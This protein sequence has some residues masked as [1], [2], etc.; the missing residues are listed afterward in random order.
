MQRPLSR[1][2]PWRYFAL[3]V[4]VLGMG[5]LAHADEL[6]EV[7][8]LYYSGQATLAMDRADQYIAIHPT[9]PQMRFTKGVMLADAKRN[10]E[11]IAVFEQLNQD[12][13]DIPEPYNNLAALYASDGV[14]YK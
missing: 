5:R 10:A 3:L 11:A 6:A 7:Q 9:D 1:L 14:F 13:P 2:R 12:Y 8:R 4:C